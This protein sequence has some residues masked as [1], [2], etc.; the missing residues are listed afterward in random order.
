MA[1]FDGFINPAAS[2]AD[3]PSLSTDCDLLAGS[4]GPLNAQA[5]ALAAR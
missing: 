2:W 4:G 1:N 5:V 3:V